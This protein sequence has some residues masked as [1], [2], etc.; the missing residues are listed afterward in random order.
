MCR[1][2]YVDVG[3]FQPVVNTDVTNTFSIAKL[4]WYITYGVYRPAYR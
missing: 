4:N 2:P 1:V 3:P